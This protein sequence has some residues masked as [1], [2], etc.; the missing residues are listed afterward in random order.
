MKNLLILILPLFIFSC[1]KKNKATAPP[2]VVKDTFILVATPNIADTVVDSNYSFEESV[3]GSDA[4]QSV[5]EQLS[6]FD[7]L[8][9]STDGKLHKGQI[10]TNSQIEEDLKQLF[11]LMLRDSFPI[12]KV[13]PVVAYNWSDSLSML[14]NNSYSFCYRNLDY[15]KHAQ[16]LAVDINP[17]FNPLMYKNK[18]RPQQPA[19]GVY[20]TLRAGTFT[21]QSQLVKEFCQRGFRWGG[22]FRSMSDYHHFEYL[23]Q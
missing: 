20:D 5:I 23:K 10:L 18:N 1:S 12:E 21:P 2:A 11:G 16:G 15:S 9:I 13:I 4:P 6:L 3:A 22:N 17:L 7:V 14:A 19:N 8:Y